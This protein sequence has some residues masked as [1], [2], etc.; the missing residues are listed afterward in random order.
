MFR[1]SCQTASRKV[2]VPVT[3]LVEKK[4]SRPNSRPPEQGAA[5][6]SYQ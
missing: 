2:K 6:S 5:A 4:R 1:T 3:P